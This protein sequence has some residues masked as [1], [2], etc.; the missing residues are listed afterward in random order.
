M[1]KVYIEESRE[2]Q[3]KNEMKQNGR[4]IEEI[5]QYLDQIPKFSKD[6][7][8]LETLKEMLRL[9]GEPQKGQK[10]IHVAGTNGKGSVCAFLSSI[11]REA[12]ATAAVFTSPHLLTVKERFAFDGRDVDDDLF[13][14]AFMAVEDSLE[15]FE[16]K[17]LG[18]PSYFEFLFLMFLV[19]VKEHPVDY[20]VLETGLGGRLD[21][22]NVV[23]SP[24]VTVIT[25]ISLDHMEY[26]GDTVGKIAGEKAGIIKDGRPVVY[27]NTCREASAVIEAKA[28]EK[29]SP[30]YPVDHSSYS[31][32]SLLG[33]RLSM[34][35]SSLE[36]E[37]IYALDIPFAAEYQAVNTMLAVRTAEL[38]G[39]SGEAICEGVR[40]AVWPGRM[41][42]IAEDV[43]L[44]GAHNEG[45]IR[46][47]AKA[48]GEI[49]A[50]KMGGRK[51][52]LF[53]VVSDKEYREMAEILCREF[54]PDVLVLTQIHYS[55]GLDIRELEQAALDAW[56][57]VDLESG[58]GKSGEAIPKIPHDVRVVET[59]EKA[60][61]EVRREKRQEDTVF[62]A[63]SLYLIGEIKKVLRRNSE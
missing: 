39:F 47:F 54:R 30:A 53:A 58:F 36:E 4:T 33:G 56:K 46:E 62:C 13:F 37:R 28:A 41:E 18:H 63:G 45:G 1:K 6:K 21:A 7:H 35:G 50:Q 5:E 52:L 2:I 51:I 10:I 57:Q 17:G 29:H 11:L 34:Q 23:E 61:D 3:M 31:G 32:L 16:K 20:V 15:T 38:L 44:D 22:T 19:M 8:S 26:L 27:D 40:R 43:Y 25:S 42:Q 55:R 48:A 14:K 12:G 59:V 9:L 60:L 49:A 24:L